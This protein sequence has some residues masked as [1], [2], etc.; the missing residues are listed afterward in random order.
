MRKEDSGYRIY[1]IDNS[2]LFRSGRWTPESITALSTQIKVYYYRSYGL[3][4]RELLTP[5]DFVPF[6]EK[7]EKLTNQQIDNLVKEIPIEWLPD[8]T[9]R[10]A[11]AQFIKQRRDM[12]R[13]IF[14]GL[15]KQ[16][17]EY[18]SGLRWLGGRVIGGRKKRLRMKTRN[19]FPSVVRSSIIQLPYK[20]RKQSSNLS[21]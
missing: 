9:E 11:I 12:I 2:H 15:C 6:L 14:H 18:R 10:L 19:T 3:L 17:P 1:A 7:V 5:S 8:E 21:H 4:L 16:I 13:D 20:I